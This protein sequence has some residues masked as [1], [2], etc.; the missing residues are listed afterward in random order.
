MLINEKY[1]IGYIKNTH[2]LKGEII[3]SIE[4]FFIDNFIETEQ[5]FID[6]D[7]L[8]VPFFIENIRKHNNNFIVKL[9][10]VDDIKKATELISCKVSV[11]KQNI[12]KPNNKVI[13]KNELIDLDVI[14]VNNILIGKVFEFL[15]FEKNQL[16]VVKDENKK[17]I[18]IP[19]N[20]TIVKK[21]KEKFIIVDLPK[22][23]I[24]VN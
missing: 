20:K 7:N 21:I 11:D 19:F 22:G 10:N 14:D 6:I 15:D 5:I 1:L 12:K 18:L 2:N 8:P 3:C 4:D 17:E 16:L 9:L 23:L 24:D 13:N